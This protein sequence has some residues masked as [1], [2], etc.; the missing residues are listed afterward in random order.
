MI[1]TNPQEEKYD[2]QVSEYVS[3]HRDF[4]CRMLHH[5]NTEARGYALA[6]LANGGSEEEIADVQREL[7]NLNDS[8][9]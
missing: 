7:E 3:E 2:D 5:G 1:D 8:A 9:E 6:L 4:L